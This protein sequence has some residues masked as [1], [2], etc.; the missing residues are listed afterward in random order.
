MGSHIIGVSMT[1][2]G[3]QPDVSVKQLVDAA[4]SGAVKDAGITLDAIRASFFANTMQGALEG[5][6]A[7][8][9]QVSLRSL[10]L[11]TWPVVNVENACASGDTALYLA[12]AHIRAGL[13]DVVLVVGVERMTHDK[14]GAFEWFTGAWDVYES[15]STAAGLLALGD[16][17]ATPDD[18]VEP[19]G[20]AKS[21]FMDI[22]GALAKYHLREYGMTARQLASVAA[23]D[24]QHSVLNSRAQYQRAFTTDEVLAAPV[25]SWPITLPMCAPMTDGAAAVILCS[26]A[27]L[28]TMDAAR[29]VPVAAIEL[30]SGSNRAP[31][32]LE[33]HLSVGA[34]AAA[35]ERAGI[36]PGDIDVAEVHDA[37]SFGEILQTENLGLVPRGDGGL[38][39][40]AGETTIG[41]RIPVNLSGGLVSKG[42]PIAAT[43]LA[44]TFELV[45]QL[46]GEAGAHQVPG[47]RWTISQGGGGFYGIEDAS[48][49]VTI[50][51]GK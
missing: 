51:G 40:E 43:G 46:R 15:D 32:E 49:C 5:Q 4:V 28:A 23:K 13:A 29:S 19:Q 6:H 3:R 14:A 26:D 36:G 48:T 22:Y 20:D 7:V 50:L 1:K 45:A 21:L 41:G 44:K 31:H 35:Y 30:R 33:R 42:H 37:T 8:A 2:F 10:G 17:V 12:D 47:A 11:D 18:V 24:H 9:G 16:G 34:A 38:A 39:A 27:A 25:I